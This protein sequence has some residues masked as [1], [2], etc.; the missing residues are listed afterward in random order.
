MAQREISS[1]LRA[2]SSLSSCH[3]SVGKFPDFQG[4]AIIKLNEFVC[5]I[6]IFS[7]IEEIIFSKYVVNND[8]MI[9]KKDTAVY[10]SEL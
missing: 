9:L 3:A 6:L 8:K 10:D 2:S 4:K 7:G 5:F 1:F